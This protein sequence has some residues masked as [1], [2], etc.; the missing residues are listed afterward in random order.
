MRPF[1]KLRRTPKVFI[2]PRMPRAASPSGHDKDPGKGSLAARSTRGTL[3]ARVRDVTDQDAWEEFVADYGPKILRWCDRQGLQEADC[4]DVVQ[5]VLSRLVVAMRSFEYD[6]ER[7]RF[8]SWLRTVTHNAVN[9]FV[10]HY[11]RPGCGSGDPNVDRILK[12]V[13]DPGTVADL[14]SVLEQQAEVELLREAESRVQLRVKPKNWLA[15]RQCVRDG[16]KSA[17]VAAASKIPVADVC[18]SA[19]GSLTQHGPPGSAEG[20][21]SGQSVFSGA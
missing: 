16:R 9:D 12:A 1:L 3:L 20:R 10:R 6:P 15:W 18:E 14:S 4:A 11:D 5:T 13:R 8:R 17:E 7:G 21:S 2:L 19:G